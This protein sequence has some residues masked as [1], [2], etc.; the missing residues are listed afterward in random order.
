MNNNKMK[1]YRFISTV[2][3]VFLSA[4]KLAA[5]CPATI[6]DQGNNNAVSVILTFN[7][8]NGN[9]VGSCNCNVAGNSGN[10]NCPV[11]CPFD[12]PGN[13][14]FTITYLDGNGNNCLYSNTGALI[15]PLPIELIYFN[16]LVNGRYINLKWETASETNNQYFIVEKSRDAVNFEFVAK[17]AAAGN[18]TSLREYSIIDNK[19]FEGVSYYRL[20]QTDFDG[21]FTYSNEKI[22][23]FHQSAIEFNVDIYP[24]PN[25]GEN[26][27]LAVNSEKGRETMIKMYDITGR[28]SFS[29][30]II[31]E[32]DGENI[33]PI[34]FPGKL[35]KG[36]Y[37]IS[38]TSDYNVLR[39]KLVVE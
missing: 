37:F 12:V 9:I 29:T 15:T 35:A 11:A 24:N 28:E 6:Q 4:F 27:T 5:Q 21:N 13:G 23:Y 16:V 22:A 8:S 20:K 19:P 1:K 17:I 38:A 7:D 33:I 18:S 36:I 10:L 26:I 30:V 2:F 31:P 3:I 14:Y 39:K 25:S 34:E 32:I